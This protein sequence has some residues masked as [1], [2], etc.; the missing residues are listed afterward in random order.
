MILSERKLMLGG[1]EINKAY[2]GAALVKSPPVSPPIE[3]G[4]F[5]PSALQYDASRDF[6]I[7][8]DMSG[9][10]SPNDITF[11]DSGNSFCVVSNQDDTI[12]VFD[13]LSVNNPNN[14]TYNASKS[15]T[16]SENMAI[17][18]VDFSP[19]GLLMFVGSSFPDRIYTY[20]LGTAWN[21]ST[22]TFVREFDLDSN[23]GT[24]CFNSDGT[25]IF[26]TNAA[27]GT[28]GT[29]DQYNLTTPYDTSSTSST[30]SSTYAVG[31]IDETASHLQM[32]GS[33]DAIL[34]SGRTGDKIYRLDLAA[35]NEI[36]N[37]SHSAANDLD[38]S[39]QEANPR[40]FSL[41]ADGNGLSM[42]G[43][44]SDTIYS[45]LLP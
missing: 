27:S 7:T 18:C 43:W 6:S 5:N 38:V 1:T 29:L 37:V 40:G 28:N 17:D 16:L 20:S 45:Y 25:R 15:V 34:M 33:D 9:V 10:F 24:F 41:H 22:A 23:L 26:A 32:G 39:G 36:A 11:I 4:A 12:H 8:A 13:C 35:P 31:L 44:N 14:A 3:G 42:I 2:F 30:P 21:P 19:D